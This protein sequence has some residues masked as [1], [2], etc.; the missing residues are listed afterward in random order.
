MMADAKNQAIVQN[1]ESS[2][3]S[4]AAIQNA[5]PSVSLLSIHLK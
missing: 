2:I 3:G 1:S 4:A 5:D